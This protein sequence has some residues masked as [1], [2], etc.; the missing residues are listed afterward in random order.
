M[1]LYGLVSFIDPHVFGDESSY[2]DQFV[3][4]ENEEMRNQELQRRL[5]PFCHRTLRRQ[6]LEYIKFTQR[7]LLTCEFYPTE[8]NSSFMRMF[9]HTYREKCLALPRAQRT[10]MTMVLRKLLASSSFAI[11]ATLQ[12]LI[13]RLEKKSGEMREAAKEDAGAVVEDLESYAETRDEWNINEIIDE[14]DIS[15]LTTIEND[16]LQAEIDALKQN[17]AL[18]ERISHNAKETHFLKPLHS[19]W[20]STQQ[21]GTRRR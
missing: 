14:K 16:Q 11:A 20:H 6:V 8:V 19:I 10:L 9:P 7:I 4:V 1:E 17:L 3:R 2:R 13:N 21:G 5:K 15:Y 18:A 12:S